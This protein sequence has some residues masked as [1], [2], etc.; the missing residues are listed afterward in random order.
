MILRT[1]LFSLLL[2]A[3]ACAQIPPQVMRWM[4]AASVQGK[5]AATPWWLAGGV[6]A[7][8]CVAAWQAK[9]AASLAASYTNLNYGGSNLLTSAV[10]PTWGTNGWVFDGST[11]YL[12]TT[13][14]P[15]TN[16]TVFVRF[17]GGNQTSG[18][19]NLFGS[20]FGDY[21]LQIIPNYLGNVIAAVYGNGSQAVFSGPGVTSGV[22]AMTHSTLYYN[23]SVRASFS[24]TTYAVIPS[25][26]I[27]AN[28][29]GFP[30]F[31][32]SGNVQAVSIYNRTLTSNEV[33]AITTAITSL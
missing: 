11:S 22:I 26:L 10:Y 25:M 24:S 19:I 9:G 21:A 7:S 29:I 6:A 8:N 27:G 14:I 4:Q 2:A 33:V 17:S 16:M 3:C 31:Y 15:S 32:W 12:D 28:D 23:S 30:S 18:Y 5:A 1:V 13:V 20:S